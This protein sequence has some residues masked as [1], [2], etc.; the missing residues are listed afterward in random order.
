MRRT[1]PHHGALVTCAAV[2]ATP[3]ECKR[4]Q[5]RPADGQHGL[6][7]PSPEPE[8]RPAPYPDL[9]NCNNMSGQD[10]RYKDLDSLKLHTATRFSRTIYSDQ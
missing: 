2:P 8:V 1:L 5:R 7:E 4:L 9:T 6:P 3:E 10:I